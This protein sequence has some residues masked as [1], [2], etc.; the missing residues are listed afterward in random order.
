VPRPAFV[1]HG[2][3]LFCLLAGCG[4]A[5]GDSAGGGGNLT[6]LDIPTLTSIAPSSVAPGTPGITLFV[7]GSNFENAATVQWNGFPLSTSWVSAGEMTATVPAGRIASIGRASVTVS[8]PGPGGGASAAQTFIISA[9]PA[10]TTWVRSVPGITTAQNIVWDP[11]HGSLYVS[12]PSTDPTIPNTIVPI[13]PLT[14]SAGTPVPAGNNPDLLS[15]SSDASYLWV[16]LDGDHAVQRFLL[17]KLTKDISLSVPLDAGK[18]PQQPVSLQAAPVNPH[19]LALVAGNWGFS[20]TGNGVYVFDD[21]T[22]RLNSVLGYTVGGQML[23]WIQWGADDSTIYGNQYT[24]IDAGGVATVNVTPA[25]ASLSS[26]NGGQIGPAFS[27]YDR[28]NGRLYSTN[29]VFNPVDGSQIGQFAIAVGERVCTADSSLGRYYCVFANQNGGTD[30]SLFELWVYDLNSYA[31]I[32]RVLFGAS[33]GVPPSS[34][35]GGLN[36]LIRWGNAGL[37]LVTNTEPYKGN[38]GLFLIDGAAVNPN[39]APDVSSGVSPLSYTSMTSLMPLQASV[40]SQDV[41]VTIKGNNFTQTSTACWN[42]NYLQFQFL[43]TSYV[44]VQQLNVTIPASLLATP[45]LLPINIF[46][47]NSNL[48]SNDSL[49][50]A[51]TPGSGASGSGTQVIPIELTGLAMAWDPNGGLLYVGTADYESAYPNSI[52]AIDG[53]S[54]SV[55]NAQTV[56]TD[57]DLLSVSA[58]GQYLYVAYAEATT[59]TQLQLPGLG[60]PRT[61]TLNN[62]SSS[63]VYW[64]GDLRAA[65]ESPHTT[66][67]DL[68][69]LRSMPDELGGVVIYDD[70]VERPNIVPG[71][72]GSSNIFD[73]I[74][75]GSSDQVLTGAAASGELGPAPLSEF[76]ISQ[77][78]AALVATGTA[79]FNEGELHSDFGTGLIYSDDG[80][81]A[82][83]T[84]QAIVG[85]YNASGLVAPDSSL[86]R[87]FILGQTAAQG[88]TN[89]FTI[90]SF[91]EKAYSPVSSITLD[92]LLGTPIELVRWGNSGLA[93]LTTNQ[94]GYGSPGMLYLVQDTS[95]ISNAQMAASR[96][97]RS[98]ELVK[99]RWKR[100]SKLDIVKMVQARTSGKLP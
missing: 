43:P 38:G 3:L 47:T 49:T 30:V 12:I 41:T 76:Q 93:V 20:P 69:N 59:M 95:F 17:P 73:T 16:G 82:D 78:G 24:T 51:V 57:P 65:P 66:A 53:K 61:W 52:V 97:S 64:A 35:T 23:D 40:G 99:R 9:T 100:I 29:R 86:N 7:F 98:Q 32:D 15:I 1:L 83:P 54:G 8:N 48:F 81:V 46:D 74:A 63:A 22:Q 96:F 72:L 26:Y 88:N 90:E 13:N 45:A 79:L 44:S 68:L 19:T 2:V 6:P 77:T 56:S 80:N 33:A 27:Q 85:T 37:A 84:T 58:N 28:G 31:L 36:H 21:G 42:C 34:V 87:V 62:P 39:A 50:F 60:S 75:W 14:A 94:S 91:D 92:N 67:V 5:G 70:N 4:G 25:G 71:F 55:V 11:A 10:A 89:S 18:N